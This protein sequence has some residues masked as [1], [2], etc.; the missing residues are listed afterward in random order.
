MTNP[1]YIIEQWGNRSGLTHRIGGPSIIYSDG[2][3]RWFLWG[4]EYNLEGYLNKLNSMG[5]KNEV[6]SML[7]EME[8]HLCQG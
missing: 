1:V 3:K 6:E 4:V 8:S 7:W 2:S 5:Y